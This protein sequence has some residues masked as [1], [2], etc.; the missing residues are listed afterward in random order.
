MS[1]QYNE[2]MIRA[3]IFIMLAFYLALPAPAL[4][5]DCLKTAPLSVQAGLMAARQNVFVAK[6]A[7]KDLPH[8]AGFAGRLEN[9][10]T[11]LSKLSSDHENVSLRREIAK[12]CAAAAETF[13]FLVT[14]EAERW[15]L[16][17]TVKRLQEN[18]PDQ[19]LFRIL[20]AYQNAAISLESAIE[21]MTAVACSKSAAKLV[22]TTV[23]LQNLQ[24]TVTMHAIK[25]ETTARQVYKKDLREATSQVISAALDCPCPTQPL[26]DPIKY[27]AGIKTNLLKSMVPELVDDLDAC[28]GIHYDEDYYWS[29]FQ[30]VAKKAEWISHLQN[31]ADTPAKRSKYD[32]KGCGP[33]SA[34]TQLEQLVLN[35][36]TANCYGYIN[37]VLRDPKSTMA[38]K[39]DSVIDLLEI[40]L[41]NF[42]DYHG[43][44]VRF[45]SFPPEVLEAYKIGAVVVDSAFMSTSRRSDWTWTGNVKLLIKSKHG[46][47]IENMASLKGER[48]VLLRPGSRFRVLNRKTVD[49]HVEIELEEIDQGSEAPVLRTIGSPE[50]K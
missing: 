41:G 20:N 10:A 45:A 22:P 14:N 30:G 42:P 35:A 25:L 33:E 49:N 7:F 47:S 24:S 6:Q 36:Y 32:A 44:V 13:R 19:S 50:D 28:C 23:A 2:G 17:L 1:Y 15:K 8:Y 11:L 26:A 37:R 21:Y 38:S 46:K 27:H 39:C 29:P 5:L 16:D 9:I 31:L 40:A 18:A 4:A 48:E 43:K 34:Y 12:E 3:R